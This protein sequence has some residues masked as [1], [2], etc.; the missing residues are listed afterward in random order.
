MLGLYAAVTRQDASGNPPGGWMPDERM[1][2]AQALR[3]FTLDASYA[4]H[5]ETLLGSIEAGKLADLVMLSADIMRIPAPEILKTTI[6]LT[7]IGG[8]IV[9]EQ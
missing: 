4:A 9:Y 5:T 6:R 3:S 2:R 1:S 8:E 7:V